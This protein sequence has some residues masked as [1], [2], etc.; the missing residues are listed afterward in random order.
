MLISVNCMLGITMSVVWKS[1]L[2][3][4]VAK[5]RGVHHSLQHTCFRHSGCCCVSVVSGVDILLVLEMQLLS[6]AVDMNRTCSVGSGRMWWG[7][8]G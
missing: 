7:Q 2:D 4:P 3:L 5:L 1:K 8:R 6:V